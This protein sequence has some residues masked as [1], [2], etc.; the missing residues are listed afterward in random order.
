MQAFNV[1]KTTKKQ[2][3]QVFIDDFLEDVQLAPLTDGTQAGHF[4]Y[5]QNKIKEYNYLKAM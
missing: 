4:K 3:F 2:L 5:R 1:E